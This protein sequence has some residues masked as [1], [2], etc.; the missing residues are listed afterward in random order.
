MNGYTTL[1][2]RFETE[3]NGE[4]KDDSVIITTFNTYERTLE[5]FTT[6]RKRAIEETRKMLDLTL[7]K[8]YDYE[9]EFDAETQEIT[10]F[11]R[12]CI[13]LA[14]RKYKRLRYMHIACDASFDD[15]LSDDDLAST[16]VVLQMEDTKAPYASWG[17][18][19]VF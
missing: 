1:M 6:S 2:L 12:D 13:K 18:A 4:V 14:Q 8:S 15:I 11:L 9:S 16:C 19:R 7:Y 17:N 3:D 5:S 10:A